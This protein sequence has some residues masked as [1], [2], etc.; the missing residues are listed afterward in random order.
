MT[1]GADEPDRQ[2]SI[3][4]S[5]HHLAVPVLERLGRIVRDL[6]ALSPD[7]DAR[8][9]A[10]LLFLQQLGE[11]Y[12]REVPAAIA[13]RAAELL[14]RVDLPEV[15]VR[16]PYARPTPPAV[17][18][19]PDPTLVDQVRAL[20]ATEDPTAPLSD[21]QLAGQLGTLR[22][23]IARARELLGAPTSARRRR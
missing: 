13:P 2:L 22:R 15:S 14:A 20:L 12:H 5:D 3:A 23:H 7:G 1:C 21:M 17:S 19:A 4:L 9:A 18:T 8:R 6:A 10:L 16:R 11:R